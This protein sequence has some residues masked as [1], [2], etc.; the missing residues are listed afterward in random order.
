MAAEITMVQTPPRP[1]KSIPRSAVV[2]EDKVRIRVSIHEIRSKTVRYHHNFWL[3]RPGGDT[4][5]ASGAVVTICVRLDAL[6][7]EMEGI[8]IPGSLRAK[9]EFARQNPISPKP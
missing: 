8:S 9:L 4:L 1:R 7:G 2:I 5:V 3:A 6:T